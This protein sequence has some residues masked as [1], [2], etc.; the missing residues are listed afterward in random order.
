MSATGAAKFI[1]DLVAVFPV[2]FGPQGTDQEKAEQSARRTAWTK[3]LIAELQA[4]DDN[5]LVEAA[6]EIKRTRKDRRFPT[7]AECLT[8]VDI[9][10]RRRAMDSYSS[11]LR[12]PTPTSPS[13]WAPK[14][15]SLADELLATEQA[16]RAAREGWISSFY[17]FVRDRGRAPEKG[18]EPQLRRAAEDFDSAYADCIRGG[19][20]H[21]MD[22]A[23]LGGSMLR[24]REELR[25]RVL[26]E[27]RQP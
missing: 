21:A 17:Q 11:A 10:K 16:R 7:V 22:L 13:V 23:K 26:G 2:H 24:R 14:F 20:P 3:S 25:A 12:L 6:S 15:Y 5:D 19:F 8:A 9:I 27:E 4:V 18:E 1:G